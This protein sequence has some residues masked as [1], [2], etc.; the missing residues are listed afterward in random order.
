VEVLVV[1]GG[2]NDDQGVMANVLRSVAR[3]VDGWSDGST[4]ASGRPE[5][6]TMVVDCGVEGI[7]IAIKLG[8]I[9][10]GERGIILT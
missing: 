4:F 1:S 10:R 3:H 2:L 7:K 9:K 6:G 8:E 5:I